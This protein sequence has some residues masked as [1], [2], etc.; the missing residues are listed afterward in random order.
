MQDVDRHRTLSDQRNHRRAAIQCR[1]QGHRHRDPGKGEKPV[2]KRSQPPVACT[3]VERED[4]QEDESHNEDN[5][6]RDK[7]LN[8]TKKDDHNNNENTEGNKD[9]KET[10]KTD[11]NNIKQNKPEENKKNN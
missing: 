2:E 7:F 5:E 6:T 8:T 11:E 10:Q 9:T 1:A 3:K 4:Q